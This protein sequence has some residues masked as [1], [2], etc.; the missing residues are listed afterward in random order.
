[1]DPLRQKLLRLKKTVNDLG[2][3]QRRIVDDDQGF[4][5]PA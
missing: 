3:S 4:S 1:M 2:K 5:G